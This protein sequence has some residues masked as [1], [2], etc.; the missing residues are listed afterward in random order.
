MVFELIPELD[1]PEV[2]ALVIQ[3]VHCALAVAGQLIDEAVGAHVVDPGALGQLLA[4]PPEVAPP[5]QL[6]AAPG[7][8]DVTQPVHCALAVAGQLVDEVVWPHVVDP[9]A[10]GQLLAVHGAD[11]VL[12]ERAV[13]QLV[14]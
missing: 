5:T 8:P 4:A 1:V 12:A 2:C 3:P 10:L 13:S 7:L 14:H 6:V 9:G 11:C